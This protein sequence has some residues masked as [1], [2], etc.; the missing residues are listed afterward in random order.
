M[1][2][3]YITEVQSDT[4]LSQD[5]DGACAQTEHSSFAVGSVFTADKWLVM[6]IT[7]PKWVDDIFFNP[8]LYENELS[9]R[10]FFNFERSHFS[11]PVNYGM[12]FFRTA[13]IASV[14]SNE[15]PLRYISFR[16]FE[17][18]PFFLNSLSTILQAIYEAFRKASD[19]FG[20][21]YA[22]SAERVLV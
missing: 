20:I 18:T 13:E 19:F 8:F 1:N 15:R 10:P 5:S 16:S 6:M 7:F 17:I 2:P 4:F 21:L 3:L 11:I 14:L 12:L 9:C 22:Q